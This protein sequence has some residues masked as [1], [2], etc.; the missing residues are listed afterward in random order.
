VSVWCV[1]GNGEPA[2]LMNQ[3]FV[4][5]SSCTFAVGALTKLIER[6]LHRSPPCLLICVLSVRLGLS[7]VRVSPNL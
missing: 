3:P 5:V 4:C 2:L 7:P 6:E 1:Y